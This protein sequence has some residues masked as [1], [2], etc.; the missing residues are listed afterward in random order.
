MKYLAFAAVMAAS[1][2]TPA[3]ASPA[4]AICHTPYALCAS[5]PTVVL[6][7]ETVTVGGKTFQAG[8]SVCPVLKG[9]SIADLSLMNGSCDSPDGT[10]KT[11]WSL[12]SNVKNYPQLPDWAV[13]PSVKR[14]FVTTTA[15]G[16]GMSNMWSFPCVVRPR[17]VNGVRLAD[18][19]GPMNE[20]PWTGDAVPVGATVGTAAPVG[21]PNPVGGNFP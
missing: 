20:S 11:V 7:G 8:L 15:P 1:T 4:L 13:L 18:C 5:S 12:F 10:D 17:K 9:E 2:S 14:T 19:R 21:L 16:G 6:E 3:I